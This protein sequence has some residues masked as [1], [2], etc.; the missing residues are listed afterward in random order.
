MTRRFHKALR[1]EMTRSSSK[2]I[3]KE[4]MVVEENEFVFIIDAH[5]T[6]WGP[7]RELDLNSTLIRERGGGGV[8]TKNISLIRRYWP[9]P[10]LID[11]ASETS[12]TLDV[13]GTDELEFYFPCFIS[14][15]NISLHAAAHSN[16]GYRPIVLGVFRLLVVNKAMFKVLFEDWQEKH[17]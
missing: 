6:A 2:S 16:T 12:F 8:F 17:D 13:Q 3:C 11:L 9:T 1:E 15:L 7:W 14:L 5:V 4:A 10:H